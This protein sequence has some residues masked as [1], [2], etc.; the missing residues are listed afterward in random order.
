M[1]PVRLSFYFS[2]H[3]PLTSPLRPADQLI[4]ILDMLLGHSGAVDKLDFAKRLSYWVRHGFPELGD[5][6]GMGLGATVSVRIDKL[7]PPHDSYR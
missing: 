3:T 1:I 2:S 6:G 4:L 5:A 7:S